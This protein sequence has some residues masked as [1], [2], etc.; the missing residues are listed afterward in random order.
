LTT[1]QTYEL[2]FSRIGSARLAR[3]L[4]FYTEGIF[5][6]YRHAAYQV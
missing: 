2:I 4:A 6:L 1:L 3:D 5:T